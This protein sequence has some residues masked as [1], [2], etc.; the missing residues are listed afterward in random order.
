M[1]LYFE[2]GMPGMRVG[3]L[4]TPR[5]QVDSTGYLQDKRNIA[6]SKH[7]HESPVEYTALGL[8]NPQTPLSSHTSSQP[9]LVLI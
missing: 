8:T 4:H 9:P 5:L 2:T 3:H 6:V 1:L 7:R